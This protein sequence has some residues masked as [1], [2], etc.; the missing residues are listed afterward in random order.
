V[1]T[2]AHTTGAGLLTDKQ[3]ARPRKLFASDAYIE[4]EATWGI[5]QR[6]IAAYTSAASALGFRSL[7]SYIAGSLLEAGS[8]RPQLHPGL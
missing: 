3:A 1:T 2:P 4:V 8:F 6:M 5:Y 7:T